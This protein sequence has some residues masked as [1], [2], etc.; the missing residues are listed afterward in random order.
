[1]VFKGAFIGQQHYG[2]HPV[3]DEAFSSLPVIAQKFFKL[4]ALCHTVL[5]ERNVTTNN[6]RY[7]AESPDEAALV[8]AAALF[9]FQLITRETNTHGSFLTLNQGLTKPTTHR[10]QLLNVIEFTSDRKRMSVIVRDC[11]DERIY[12][13]CKGADNVMKSLMAP[14]QEVSLQECDTKLDEYAGTGLRTL[15]VGMREVDVEGYMRWSKRCEE[16]ATSMENREALLA[17]VCVCVCVCVCV[18]IK[19]S[20]LNFSVFCVCAEV[21]LEM[22]CQLE[23]LG[24]SAI[25]DKLQE[26]VPEA[27]SKLTAAGIRGFDLCVCFVCV[28]VCVF[29]NFTQHISL[30]FDW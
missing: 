3:H 9:G 30:G 20:I 15:M 19:I 26:G 18:S 25:E 21:S 23:L 4:L 8:A 13:L 10:Y 24:V 16:A 1:M 11:S 28:C 27:I 2:D 12:V 29:A 22:E 5:V 7:N 6:I 17:G 14:G